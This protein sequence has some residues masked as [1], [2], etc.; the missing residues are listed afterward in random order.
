MQNKPIFHTRPPLSLKEL[1]INHTESPSCINKEYNKNSFKSS[2]STYVVALTC[3]TNTR[4]RS[5]PL[6]TYDTNGYKTVKKENP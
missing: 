2:P 1:D 3:K 4:I 5:R 6:L